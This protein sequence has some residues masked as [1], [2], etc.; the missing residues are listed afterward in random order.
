MIDILLATYNGAPYLAQQ[1]DS[2]LAQSETDWR[3]VIRDDGSADETAA[4]VERYRRQYP[5]KLFPVPSGH[6][7]GSAMHN[8]FALL[9]YAESEYV[10]FC[11]Q[12]DIW[13]PDKIALSVSKMKEMEGRYGPATPLLVHTDLCVVN[14]TLQVINPS[15]FAMQD[16]DYRRDT[17]NRLLAANIVTGCTMLFN[18]ALLNL[19]VEKPKTAVM[20]D[21][22]I[23]LVAAAFGRIGFIHEAT[24]LYRQHGNNANGAKDVKSLAYYK[25]KLFHRDKIRETLRLQYRQAGEFLRIYQ[26]QLTEEQREMLS[27][28]A[29]F[30]HLGAVARAGVLFRYG[31]RKKGMIPMLGQILT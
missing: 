10:M 21:M 1:L 4:I 22:W 2:V 31:V 6:P 9:D 8:F 15:L 23:A 28:Y 25:E 29:G 27:A 12:D 17:L 16:M 5:D 26:K 11:D 7:S 18:R 30:E 24:V 3:L 19:L 20:H 14:E 13:K